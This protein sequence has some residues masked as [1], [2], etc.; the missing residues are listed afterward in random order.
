MIIDVTKEKIKQLIKEKQ[1]FIVCTYYIDTYSSFYTSKLNQELKMELQDIYYLEVKEF[2]SLFNLNKKIFPLF[3]IFINGKIEWKI[4]GFIK[5]K[6][7]I[8]KF[9]KNKP[10]FHR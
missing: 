1:N 7:I 4:C 5:Y 2:M 10:F 3:L 6:E 8:N 9:Q